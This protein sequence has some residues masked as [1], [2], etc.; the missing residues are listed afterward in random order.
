MRIITLVFFIFISLAFSH[1]LNL[2]LNQE[3][4]KVYASAYFATG[5]FCKNCDITVRNQKG[6]LIQ[7][8]KTD[9]K[10]EFIITKLAPTIFVDVKTLEGHAAKYIL[11]IE[12]IKEKKEVKI[13]EIDELKGEINRL[14][15]ENKLLKE[16]VEQ[17]EL[18]KMIF[19]LLVILGI[20][21][22]LKK[23]KKKDE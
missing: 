6:K 18:I 10:G 17:N 11:N 22:I 19:A 4:N 23:I 15:S 20:F 5:S 12:D 8:G 16:K 21:F 3:S 1:R 14:K 13:K 7:S 2:F 9:E